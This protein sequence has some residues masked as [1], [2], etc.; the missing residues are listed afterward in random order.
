MF[1]NLLMPEEISAMILRGDRLL[2]AG[3]IELLSQLPK[4]NWVGGT[5]PYFILY[6]EH[7]V[8]SHDR[9]F[10]CTLPEYVED[11]S[12]R[13]YSVSSMRDIYVNAP[14]NGF[15]VLIMPFGSKVAEEFAL[16]AVDY[17]NFATYPICGWL[18][19]REPETL[20]TKPSHVVS[21]IDGQIYTDNGVAMHIQLPADKYAELHIFNPY[22][23]GK[24]D[25]ISFD[26]GGMVLKDAFINGERRNFA[27][28]LRGINYKTRSPLV[29]NYSGTMI[30]VS[31]IGAKGD[32]VYMYAPVYPSV[33]YRIGELDDTIASPSLISS[34]IVFS[35]TCIINFLQPELCA[36]FLQKMNG[37]VAYGEVAYQLLNQ[38]TVYVT[39]GDAQS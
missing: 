29:A 30:N 3:D 35:V 21:G 9:V 25:N 1:K 14:K 15:T 36:R 26:Y 17:K 16:H 12:I 13:K 2:L 7:M 38:T 19:G 6:P 31:F 4:G 37:S 20:L 5:T 34:D 11:V 39:V 24:G 32:T 33:N 22:K 8:T 28:Y 18:S 23:Q 10:A 27:E